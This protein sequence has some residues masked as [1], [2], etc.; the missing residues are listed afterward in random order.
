[1]N[2]KQER[3]VP[4]LDF[5]VGEPE[6]SLYSDLR[7]AKDEIWAR[8]NDA[9]LRQEVGAFLGGDIPPPFRLGPRA[10]KA[11]HITS[12]DFG[13]LRFFELARQAGLSP[14]GWEL[15]ADRFV[16]FNPDKMALVKLAIFDRLNKRGKPTYR[17]IRVADFARGIEG[18][19]ISALSTLWGESLVA[20]HHRLVNKLV[21]HVEK[22]DASEWFQHNGGRPRF[23]YPKLLALAVC[24]GILFETFYSSE[25]GNSFTDDIVWPA[26]EQV[27]RLFGKAPLIVPFVPPEEADEPHWLIYPKAV[28]EML[29]SAECQRGAGGAVA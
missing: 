29:R 10:I 22:F 11:A 18:K 2:S 12:V 17:F 28:G 13:S 4:G 1:M 3:R 14:L 25:P 20:F 19:S 23:F 9:H 6:C 15:R 7:V 8:W 24:H 27:A 26:F 5:P 21:G 16:S